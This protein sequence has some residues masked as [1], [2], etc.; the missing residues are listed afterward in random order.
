MDQLDS[1]DHPAH[2]DNP[3]SPAQSFTAQPSTAQYIPLQPAILVNVVV[4]VQV[5]RILNK[6]G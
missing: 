2:L 3:D 5:Q 6:Y 1:N 4:P